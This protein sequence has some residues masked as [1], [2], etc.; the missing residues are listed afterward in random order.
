MT[1]QLSKE[2]IRK[3]RELALCGMHKQIIAEEL[4]IGLSTVYKFAKGIH[5]PKK[6]NQFSE[7]IIQKIREEVLSGKSKYQIAKERGLKFGAV[8]YHTQ[9]LPNHMYRE[10]GLTGKL[11]D[12]LKELLK[13]GYVVSTRENT[14]RL[15]RL[16]RYLPMIQRSQI[17]GEAVYYLNDK[18]KIALQSIIQQRKSKIFCYQE[19]AEISNV[20][21]VNLSKKEKLSLLGRKQ[22]K[23]TCKNH[24]FKGNSSS[25]SDDFRGRFLHSDVLSSTI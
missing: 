23:N 13:D 19:L 8:Y 10:E 2:T 24:G 11:L 16:K 25:G 7:E 18:N 4:G 6:D 21:D 20:F 17:S 3:I 22:S 9:D 5:A 1:E 15:R 14:H 12:L